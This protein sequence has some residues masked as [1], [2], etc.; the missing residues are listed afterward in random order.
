[1]IKN[2]KLFYII[3]AILIIITITTLILIQFKG[4]IK[5]SLSEFC[6]SS[7][8]GICNDDTSCITGG[9]SGQVCQSESE[10]NIVTTCEMQECYNNEKYNL[11]CKCISNKCEWS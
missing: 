3:I 4:T 9:C 1:M 7:T 11:E 10:E 5:V 6:G 8:Y 2:K